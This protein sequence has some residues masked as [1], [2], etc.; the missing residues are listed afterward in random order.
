MRLSTKV[1]PRHAALSVLLLDVNV[2]LGARRDDHPYHAAV[3]P[4]FDDVLAGDDP[5][6]VPAVVWASILRLATNR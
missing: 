6:T 4:W 1:G 5:F 3:R 2:V